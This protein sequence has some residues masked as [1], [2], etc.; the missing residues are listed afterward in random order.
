MI[1]NKLSP[2]QISK[3]RS[4]YS[5][6][7]KAV[8]RSYGK[9]WK[10][11]CGLLACTSPNT[12]VKANLTLARKAYH[13][14]KATGSPPEAGFLP[15]H[16]KCMKHFIGH[17]IPSGRK[18]RAFYQ[19]LIGNESVVTIDV[20][21]MRYAGLD[22]DTPSAREYM[23]I[24]DRVR[25]EAEEIGITPAQRQAEIWVSIRGSM[26]IYGISYATLLAQTE[27]MFN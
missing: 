1:V 15:A 17:G 21:M 4:W 3:A 23:M 12:T 19:N 25:E 18:V 6:S 13:I 2:R 10:L 7:R 20:W 26:S 11:F 5:D 22:H 14:I 27:M 24:Q 8:K 9:E 16:I